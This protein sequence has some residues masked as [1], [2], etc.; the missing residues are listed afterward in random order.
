MK[1]IKII[2][3]NI[4][5]VISLLVVAEIITR[6][7]ISFYIGNSSAGLNERQQNLNYQPFVM[8]GPNWKNFFYNYERDPNKFV[9]MIIG[10][11][12]A[13]GFPEK[14]F[15][16][17]IG[18]KIKK[19]VEIINTGTGGYNSK[20]SYIILSI[21]G[22]KIKPDL[23]ICFDGGNDIIHSL[24]TKES[25]SF[26]LNSTYKLYLTKPFLSPLI[27]LIQNSQLYN[28]IIRI[29]ARSKEYNLNDYL[30]FI[31]DYVETQDNIINFSNLLEA[32]YIG[33]LQPFSIFKTPLHEKEK[34]NYRYQYRDEIVK[35]IYNITNQKLKKI[36]LEK[37]NS[38][39]INGAEL[40]IEDSR[41]IFSDDVHFVDNKGYEVIIGKIVNIISKN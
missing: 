36:Y 12:A 24:I 25:G 26:Y 35:K 23:I 41:W 17:A 7:S 3:I 20:Q 5:I 27:W 19:E 32:K 8:F 11:S 13:A 33:I 21:W 37:K 10:G 16:K 34:L 40:F 38:H 2:L 4:L 9:V 22:S 28:A 14:I 18:S 1:I 15:K 29:S 30:E 39:Y 6:I 31:D